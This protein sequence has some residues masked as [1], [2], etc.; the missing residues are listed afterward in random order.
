M[1]KLNKFLL[2]QLRQKSL[3]KMLCNKNHLSLVIQPSLGVSIGDAHNKAFQ[4]ACTYSALKE[5]TVKKKFSI[6][7]NAVTRLFPNDV[8]FPLTNTFVLDLYWKIC[9]PLNST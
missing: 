7:L 3:S 6:C 5:I 2:F 8:L 9:P 4:E 1:L